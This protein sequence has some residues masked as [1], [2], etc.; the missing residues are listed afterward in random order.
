MSNTARSRSTND[1]ILLLHA[2]AQHSPDHIQKTIET[3]EVSKVFLLDFVPKDVHQ[4]IRDSLDK[5]K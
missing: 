1:T 2:F 4:Y 5:T 3:V